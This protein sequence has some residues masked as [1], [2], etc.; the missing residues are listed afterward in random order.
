M[1]DMEL[2]LAQG[3]DIVSYARAVVEGSFR[4][5]KPTAPKSLKDVFSEKRGVFVTLHKK[6]SLRGCIGFPEPVLR[7]GDAV[8]NSAL[9]AAFEDPRFPSVDEDELRQIDVEVS[10]LTK[11]AEVK[12]SDSSEYVKNIVIGRDGLIAELGQQRGLLLPQVPVEQGWG[13][14]EF[15]ENTCEKAW[16]PPNA[17]LSKGFRLYSFSAQIFSEEKPRGNVVE[18]RI[19]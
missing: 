16:L 19:I 9:S 5:T 8:Y 6:G 15:L 14:Q 10:V 18:K 17:Y 11:P 1:I 4:K 7:L 2:D 12:V 13:P 3:R